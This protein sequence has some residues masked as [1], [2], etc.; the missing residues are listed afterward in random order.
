MNPNRL[1]QA[2]S[3]VA[4]KIRK[5]ESADVAL[6]ITGDDL[7]EWLE[8]LAMTTIDKTARRVKKGVR[9]GTRK[10]IA[11]IQLSL[12]GLEHAAL[13]PIVWKKDEH[14]FDVAVPM[15]LA[16]KS[17][18]RREVLNNRRVVNLIDQVVAG[19]EATLGRLD[20]LGVPDEA[21]G[22]E[23]LDQFNEHGEIGDADA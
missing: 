6:S 13:P 17:E 2:I 23:I 1:R 12:P 4:E 11:S 20:E 14:G 18:I 8:D 16:S 10:G 9:D 3:F 15:M 19:W 22:H 7:E 5:G 21:T